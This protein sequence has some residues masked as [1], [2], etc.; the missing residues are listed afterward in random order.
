[1]LPVSFVAGWFFAL[2]KR[3]REQDSEHDAELRSMRAAIER[4][5][6]RI[7]PVPAMTTGD[8]GDIPDGIVHDDIR[9]QL[10]RLAEKWGA[11]PSFVLQCAVTHQIVKAWKVE[12]DDTSR[13]SGE[14]HLNVSA[15]QDDT[16]TMFEPGYAEEVSDE[17]T[18]AEDD[19]EPVSDRPLPRKPV[20]H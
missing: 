14:V 2:R 17:P 11:T 5:G 10:R 12:V 16:S 9:D 13:E 20:K 4:I 18:A 8:P 7:A 1:M 15:A 19:E 3:S 6:E